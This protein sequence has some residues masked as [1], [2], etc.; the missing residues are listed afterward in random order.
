MRRRKGEPLKGWIIRGLKD[1]DNTMHN[2]I[3]REENKAI[4][5][6]DAIPADLKILD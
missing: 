3:N 4:I 1:T 5:E 6:F 2:T